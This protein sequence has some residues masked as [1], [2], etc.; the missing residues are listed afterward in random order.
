VCSSDLTALYS[1]QWP[2]SSGSSVNNW[3]RTFTTINGFQITPG[4]CAGLGLSY[5]NYEIPA[6]SEGTLYYTSPVTWA[7]PGPYAKLKDVSFLP[8]NTSGEE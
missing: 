5:N 8:S 2:S 4:F 6:I 3:F 7:N 1:F